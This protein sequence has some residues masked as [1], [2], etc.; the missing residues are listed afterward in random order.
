MFPEDCRQRPSR[1][2]PSVAGQGLLVARRPTTM[3]YR[4]SAPTRTRLSARNPCLQLAEAL[5]SVLTLSPW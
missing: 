4:D 2:F 3:Q 1:T 5:C